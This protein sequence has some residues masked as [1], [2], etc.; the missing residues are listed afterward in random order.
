M[1]AV[2]WQDVAG[3]VLAVSA[4]VCLVVVLLFP[5]KF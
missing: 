2:Q 1:L 4:L 3:L 5:E